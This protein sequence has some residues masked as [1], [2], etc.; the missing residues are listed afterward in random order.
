MPQTSSQHSAAMG[1]SK[2][3][4]S[5]LK[6]KINDTHKAGEGYKKVAKLFQV[7]IPSV[8]NQIRKRQS[9]GTKEVKLRSG[10]QRKLSERATCRFAR[11]ETAKDLQEDLADSGE[12]IEVFGCNEQRYAGR[13]KGAE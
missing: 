1:S 4:P 9:T 12:K 10:R 2:K 3:M 11:K 6:T 8:C 7:V 5:T 13:K